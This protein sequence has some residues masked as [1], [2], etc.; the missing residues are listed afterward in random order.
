V[1]WFGHANSGIRLKSR[2]GRPLSPAFETIFKGAA[3][4]GF[5]INQTKGGRKIMKSR[6]AG[7]MGA[8][9]LASTLF[10]GSVA[11]GAATASSAQEPSP[12]PDNT[13]V[14]KRDRQSGAMTA[15]QQKEN[16]SDRNTTR[17]IRQAVMK[18]K[19]L[20]MYAHNVK[21]LTENGV[22]TLRGPV[23]SDEEKQAIEAKAKQVAGDDK[24]TNQ[25]E[26]K[27]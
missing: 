23:R 4:K 16:S 1:N 19:S 9:L 6:I 3:C 18:D 11:S 8:V 5:S 12:A 14:N 22:V 24:V 10:A 27:Q 13:K 15:G 25:L 26:V 7:L 20:S 17:Q 21:I 2:V